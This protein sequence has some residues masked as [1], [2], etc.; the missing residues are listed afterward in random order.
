MSQTS[1]L[2]G[3]PAFTDLSQRER[4]TLL[5]IFQR[6]EYA[7]GDVLCRE[8]DRPFTFFIVCRGTVEISKLVAAGSSEKLGE[9]GRGHMVGQVS[10]IDGKPRSATVTAKTDVVCLE[11]S[12]DD[13][14]R[15]FT[16]GSPFAFKVLDQ[17]V[18]HLARRL[19]DANRQVYNLYSR[20]TETILRL[21]AACVGIQR[22]LAD[23]YDPDGLDT[24][25]LAPISGAVED[26][27]AASVRKEPPR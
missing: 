24:P 20:P 8:G 11:C 16:A 3:I 14:E 4:G 12:R 13:F 25:E 21:H 15:L 27:S 5:A 6:R 10:L 18:I 1:I 23:S 2:D 9:L 22:S 7:P 17:I 19:R 26:L